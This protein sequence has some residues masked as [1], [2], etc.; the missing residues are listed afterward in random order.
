[1]Q[2]YDLLSLPV[3]DAG[4]RLLGIITHEDFIETVEDEATED[5]QRF[6]GSS[7][8]SGPYLETP[9]INVARRRAGWLFL[10]FVTETLTGSVL[11]L[12]EN[13]LQAVVSLAFFIPLLIGTGGNA[14]S[15]TT[16]T[17]I[18]GIA[19]GDIR[20]RDG[21]RVLWHELRIGILLGVAMAV[22]GFGRALLWGTGQDVAVAVAAALLLVVTWAN[23]VG[24][25]LPVLAA[26]LKIDP[27]IVSGPFMSTLVDATGLLIYL[28]VAKLILKL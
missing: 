2:R 6:G 21:L 3:V 13:E 24:S 4:G 12:F 15:Q 19:T 23:V 10:L 18:R 16:A 1:M 14:G 27:A 26:R 22:I 28:S 9:V 8:L 11:R 7:P 20:L 17:I 25:L 5:I